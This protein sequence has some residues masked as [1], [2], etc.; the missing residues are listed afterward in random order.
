MQTLL[1]SRNKDVKGADTPVR[2]VVLGAGISDRKI[3]P[4]SQK[5]LFFAW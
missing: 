5:Q 1:I 4:L 3:P 2:T